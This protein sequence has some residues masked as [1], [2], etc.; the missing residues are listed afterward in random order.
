MANPL[1]GNPLRTREDVE[2][3]AMDLFTPLLPHFSKGAARVKLGSWGVWYSDGAGELEGFARPLWGIVP[4]VIARRTVIPVLH[5]KHEAGTH[6]LCCA[7]LAADAAEVP[8][9]EQPPQLP[10]E[11]WS[12]LERMEGSDDAR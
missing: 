8:D 2:R 1:A 3:A 6:L 9:W 10:D 11:A 5:A 4:L 7:V 12:L